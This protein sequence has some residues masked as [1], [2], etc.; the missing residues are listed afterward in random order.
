VE[1]DKDNVWIT[2][3]GKVN[4][5]S[6]KS[7]KNIKNLAT[8]DWTGDSVQL[9]KAYI[10]AMP[11]AQCEQRMRERGS[12]DLVI[13]PKQMCAMG[14]PSKDPG[15]P[16]VDTCQGDS[17]GPAVKMVDN[18]KEKSLLENWTEDERNNAYMKIVQEDGLPPYRGQLLGVTSW[19][20]GCGEGTPGIYTRVSEYL[21][22]IKKYTGEM[23]T[24]DDKI[25]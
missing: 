16:V 12:E 1:G 18:F 13:S 22:W 17:G 10:A 11:N 3:F 5:T 23:S 24:P 25:F 4:S 21:T 20:Y 2:G 8:A 14:I 15:G 9:M 6:L 7:I 19:G